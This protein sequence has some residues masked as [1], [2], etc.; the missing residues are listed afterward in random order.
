MEYNW[1]KIFNLAE[2][3]ATGLVSRKYTLELE[4]LG[5]KEILATNGNT[6]SITYE[7]VMLAVNLNNKNP[8]EFDGHA[9]YVS[10]AEDV[11][12]GIAVG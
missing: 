1:Y 7:G 11:Y 9:V 12:L 2:F 3:I 10:E 6:I 8:F 5:Q 4:D